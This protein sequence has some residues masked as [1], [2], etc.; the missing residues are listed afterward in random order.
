M[1]NIGLMSLIMDGG[2]EALG[3]PNLTVNTPEQEGPDVS[4]QGAPLEIGTDGL[5]GDRRQAQFFCAK[6]GHKQTS[7]KLYGKD[8]TRILFY[9]RFTRGLSI[10]MKNSG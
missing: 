1:I 6:I 3:Q 4:G 2:G 5:P 7:C 8:W 10:F 9:Q